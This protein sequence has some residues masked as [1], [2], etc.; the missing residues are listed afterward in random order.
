MPEPLARRRR[1]A[2]R[3]LG[4]GPVRAASAIAGDV[5]SERVAPRRTVERGL[6]VARS[7]R[8]SERHTR[9]KTHRL[10]KDITPI[11]SGWDY[12]PD[13]LQVRI[14]AGDDGR[15]KIQ[16]RIDL[17]LIQME[18]AGRPDGAAPD[19]LESLLDDLEAQAARGRGRGERSH[20]TPT[21]ARP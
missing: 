1:A 10:S 5:A 9:E 13:E 18:L 21:P 8:A 14:V 4:L 7:D 15:D 17:G 16:M 11:L 2:H 20:S 6:T 12:D 3:R 19:G